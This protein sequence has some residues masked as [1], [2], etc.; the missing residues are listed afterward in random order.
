M[1]A[2]IAAGLARLGVAASDAQ[3]DTLV[4]F[5]DELLRWNARINLSAAR[6][7]AD[8]AQHVV[9]SAAVVPWI[10]ATTQR[11]IDVGSGGGLPAVPVAILRPELSVVAL[12]P[13]HKKHAFLQHARRA[14][15]LT[16]LEARAERVEDHAGRGYDVAESRATFA[17]PEWLEI[18]RE[19]VRPGGV[20]LAMEGAEQ[21]NLPGR[22]TRH[23]YTLDDR[24]RSIV[25]L[26]TEDGP[27]R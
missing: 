25:V 2:A 4:R 8:M 5:S 15:G 1:R 22:A 13:I 11:V 19:L 14:L 27:T 10:P 24:T 17:L 26:R 9:D 16:N 18:G 20:V 23:P 6:T 12:E 3:V 21:H 7:P